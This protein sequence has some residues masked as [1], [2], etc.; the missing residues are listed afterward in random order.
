MTFLLFLVSVA[1]LEQVVSRR[2][3]HG[4][5]AV[6]AAETPKAKAAASSSR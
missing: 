3:L 1:V 6:D 5:K 2:V 4:R